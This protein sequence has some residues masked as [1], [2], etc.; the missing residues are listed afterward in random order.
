[1][2]ADWV[3]AVTTIAREKIRIR[4]FHPKDFRIVV[5]CRRS[6]IDPVPES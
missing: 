3:I 5:S 6:T 2:I 1:M 4:A